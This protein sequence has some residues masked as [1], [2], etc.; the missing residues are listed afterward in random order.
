[1]VELNVNM[2]LAEELVL[3]Q[4]LKEVIVVTYHACFFLQLLPSES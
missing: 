3:A 1:M 2:V 4:M